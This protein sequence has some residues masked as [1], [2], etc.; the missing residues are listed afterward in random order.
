MEKDL[1]SYD[2]EGINIYFLKINGFI[3]YLINIYLFL[4]ICLNQVL[5]VS[6]G[7]QFPDQGLNPGPLHEECGILATGPPGKSLHFKICI[8]RRN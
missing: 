2:L 4:F 6:C 3:F 5:V 1:I 7:V 8:H